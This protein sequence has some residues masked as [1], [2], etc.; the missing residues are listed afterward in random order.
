MH[1]GRGVTTVS[2]VW[3]QIQRFSLKGLVH[4]Y[5]ASCT[6]TLAVENLYPSGGHFTLKSS[7]VKSKKWRTHSATAVRRRKGE[8]PRTSCA[9]TR[10]CAEPFWHERIGS[11]SLYIFPTYGVGDGNGAG[12]GNGV[13]DGVGVGVGDAVTVTEIVTCSLPPLGSLVEKVIVAVLEPG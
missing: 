8:D 11:T 3:R 2:Y 13:G 4:A 1:N 6:L 7:P 12:D 9:C 5:R 10:M